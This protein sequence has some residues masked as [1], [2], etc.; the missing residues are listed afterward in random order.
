MLI[1][2]AWEDQPG[3]F[4]S[5]FLHL[6]Y[7]LYSRVVPCYGDPSLPEFY[8]E[9]DLK[10][11]LLPTPIPGEWKPTLS[12]T[13]TKTLKSQLSEVASS[14]ALKWA[15]EREEKENMDAPLKVK[16][17]W[18]SADQQ[19]ALGMAHL[20]PFNIVATCVSNIIDCSYIG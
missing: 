20:Q 14:R 2:S 7:S 13:A 8:A 12:S 1:E 5:T 4:S 15:H 11:R 10:S 6:S 17:S 3:R 19:L 9:H 16:R 18:M